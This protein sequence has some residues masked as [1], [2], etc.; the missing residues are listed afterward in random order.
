MNS[1]ELNEKRIALHEEQK[2]FLDAHTKE[3]GTMSAEDAATYEQMDAEF[4]EITNSIKR[5]TKSEEVENELKKAVSEPLVAMPQVADEKTGIASEGYKSAFLNLIKSDFAEKFTNELSEGTDNKGGYLVPKDWAS[6]IIKQSKE[7]VVMRI[8]GRSVTSEHGKLHIPIQDSKFMLEPVAEGGAY[9]KRDWT[10]GELILELKKMGGT[11]L[12]TEELLEDNAY[13]LESEIKQNIADAVQNTEEHYFMVGDGS[14]VPTGIFDPNAGGFNAGT[15]TAAMTA[16]DI[17]NLEYDVKAGYRKNGVFVTH[18]DVVRE[19]RKLKDNDGQYLWQPSL[20]AGE[21]DKF[22]GHNVYVS[23]YAPEKKIAFGD[24]GYYYMLGDGKYQSIRLNEV[25]REVG[26]F[27]FQARMRF[28]GKLGLR[29]AV[30]V[31][32]LQDATEKKSNR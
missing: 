25:Y 3:D 31:L 18:N 28:D 14:N 15:L 26:K 17:I 13:N 7:N 19:M 21:P 30:G 22:D 2:K 20:V 4:D 8:L 29:E 1:K 32:K 10:Y 16:D 24:F 5:A 27:G 23:D 11:I 12:V 6:F 9:Q